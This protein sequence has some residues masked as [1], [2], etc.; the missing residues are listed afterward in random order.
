MNERLIHSQCQK[1]KKEKVGIEVFL[2]A[3]FANPV[4]LLI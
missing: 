4:S 3:D 2:G 1:T